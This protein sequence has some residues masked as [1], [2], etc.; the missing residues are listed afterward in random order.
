MFVGTAMCF[1]GIKKAADV[2]PKIEKVATAF[3]IILIIAYGCVL[4]SNLHTFMSMLFQ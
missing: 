4:I 3:L 1:V 2:R